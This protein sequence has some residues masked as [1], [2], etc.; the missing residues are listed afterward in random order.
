MTR[1]QQILVVDDDPDIREL[2]RTVLGAAGYAIETAANGREALERLAE[3]AWD[4]VLL[5]IQ[6][7]ELS[8][9]ETLRLMKTDERFGSVPVAM[10][11][12]RGEVHD[13]LFGLQEGAV[14]YITKPFVVDELVARVRRLLGT[15]AGP[16]R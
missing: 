11:S 5:D 13:R 12:V 14:D 9:W 2:A 7:P 1:R 3:R 6:M 15:A 4:L 8:G 16:T 10:F